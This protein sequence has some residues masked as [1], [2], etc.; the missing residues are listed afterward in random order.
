ME[1]ENQNKS[2]IDY[3]Y[4]IL[5]IVIIF[6]LIGSISYYY[7]NS[8]NSANNTQNDSQKNNQNESQ[9]KEKLLEYK[10]NIIKKTNEHNGIVSKENFID[11]NNI[12]KKSTVKD[13]NGN[14]SKENFVDFNSYGIDNSPIK[15]YD[16]N[17]P[18]SDKGK[19]N[20]VKNVSCSKVFNPFFKGDFTIKCN[21]DKKWEVTNYNCE[22]KGLIEKKDLT[23]K[24]KL[25]RLTDD[26]KNGIVPIDYNRDMSDEEK[27]DER[28][29]IT[30]KSFDP[31]TGKGKMFVDGRDIDYEYINSVG[32][33]VG[34]LFPIGMTFVNNDYNIIVGSR[35]FFKKL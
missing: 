3:K 20:D 9:N 24:W 18:F 33:T 10:K 29:Y 35:F 14:V 21:T 16:C 6:L 32:Y 13:Y 26:E 12:I 34:D 19:I 4:I 7:Y 17:G 11:F 22:T 30:F 23:G 27:L 5:I 8:K 25:I 1:Q 28:N 31:V 2:S 15:D